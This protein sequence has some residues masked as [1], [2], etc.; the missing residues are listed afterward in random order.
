MR[1]RVFQRRLVVFVAPELA[2]E[3]RDEPRRDLVAD[4][5]A[6]RQEV[7]GLDLKDVEPAASARAP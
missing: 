2:A 4:R 7:A 5:H 3:P 6:R 1:E